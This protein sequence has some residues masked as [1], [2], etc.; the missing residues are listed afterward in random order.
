MN[1]YTPHIIATGADAI[2]LAESGA[3]VQL[4]KYQDPIETERA[5]TLDE[6]REIA[7]IDASLIYAVSALIVTLENRAEFERDSYTMLS[8]T[9]CLTDAPA[10]IDCW[11]IADAVKSEI[12]RQ[13]PDKLVGHVTLY[14]A[15]G[16][17]ITG[18]CPSEGK[19]LAETL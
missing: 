8:G 19:F 12:Q 16:R 2:A 3:P 6:A 17:A 4:R 11:E 13:F 18:D 1:T 15:D 5:V 9:W 14:H 7:R 10:E